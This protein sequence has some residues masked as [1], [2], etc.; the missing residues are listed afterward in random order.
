MLTVI[1]AFAGMEDMYDSGMRNLVLLAAATL[2]AAP[3]AAEVTIA[4]HGFV[5]TNSAIVSASPAEVWAALVEPSRYW[6]GDHSWS[7]DA[8]HFSLEPVAGGCF[9]ERWGEGNSVEHM[10]VIMVQPGSI[11]RLSGALGPLQSEGLAGALT[12]QLEEIE[13]GTRI[14]QTMSVG[15]YMQFDSETMPPIVDAVVR[16]QLE[17]LAALF[18]D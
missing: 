13:D 1:P 8:T 3:A 16:E 10:R 14:T 12:W 5:T 2:S 15:G 11:L 6:N 9:C 4:D 7:G 17:R 18:A